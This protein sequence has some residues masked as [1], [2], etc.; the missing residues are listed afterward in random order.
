MTKKHDND[1]DDDCKQ[2]S[3]Q[4]RNV[5]N[6]IEVNKYLVD[7]AHVYCNHLCN[8]LFFKMI[9]L[10]DRRVSNS[11]ICSPSLLLKTPV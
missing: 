2:K 9:L 5:L 8:F 6:L 4:S 11:T 3:G 1:N 7:V 10:A